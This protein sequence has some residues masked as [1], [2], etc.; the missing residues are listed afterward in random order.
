[1]VRLTGLEPVLYYYFELVPKTSGSP[2]FPH[3]RIKIGTVSP[4][5]T[6]MDIQLGARSMFRFKLPKVA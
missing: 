3:K 6:L 1:M 5:V 2:E 4:V